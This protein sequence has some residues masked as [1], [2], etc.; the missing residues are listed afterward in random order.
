MHE[1][2]TVISSRLRRAFPQLIVVVPTV[3]A[4]VALSQRG[5]PPLRRL[6]TSASLGLILIVLTAAWR[7][8]Q[9]PRSQR[10]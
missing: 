2:L 8:F 10:Q 5:V 9:T 7:V 6:V 3:L 1:H 4:S